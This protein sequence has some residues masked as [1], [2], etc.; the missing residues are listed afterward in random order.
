[1]IYRVSQRFEIV[2][3]LGSRLFLF[4]RRSLPFVNLAPLISASKGDV[5][6]PQVF[7]AVKNQ[8]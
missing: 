6:I 4:A 8:K 7:L 3:K 2:V 5:A 1:M